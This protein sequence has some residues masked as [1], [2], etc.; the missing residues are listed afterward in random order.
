MSN[1]SDKYKKAHDEL[2]ISGS[3]ISRT[4]QMMRAIRDGEYFET[5]AEKREREARKRRAVAFKAVSAAAAAAACI[6]A[7]VFIDQ[8]SDRGITARSDMG[9]PAEEVDTADIFTTSAVPE[10]AAA[11]KEPVF[12]ET[13]PSYPVETEITS[14]VTEAATEIFT[15]T[16]IAET[17]VQ[18]YAEEFGQ[19]E[20]KTSYFAET[21]VSYSDSGAVNVG[22]VGSSNNS[23]I[24][25][26]ELG[27][28]DMAD[29][30]VIGGDKSE[31]VTDEEDD[32]EGSEPEAKE[33]ENDE[34]VVASAL[35]ADGAVKS[36]DCFLSGE[37]TA[38]IIQEYT[39]DKAGVTVEPDAEYTYML[40]DFALLIDNIVEEN[41][42]N[43]TSSEG[44]EHVP[45][46]E[47]IVDMSD[48]NGDAVRICIASGR[49]YIVSFSGENVM[50][51]VF[52][53]SEEELDLIAEYSD[54]LINTQK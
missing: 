9:Y 10:T 39:S 54:R 53:L 33:S 34:I 25:E 4:E 43:M 29:A 27:Y 48:D 52:E 17:S 31:P 40:S 14:V 11:A 38:V 8:Y 23:I 18:V 13:D 22:I 37:Y 41:K 2:K 24:G 51:Y 20:E 3:F 32:Q 16:E 6:G 46:S 7:V 45:V 30:P 50:T 49:M 47:Y 15:E 28:V 26:D 21:H 1:F 12:A 36:M 42:E 44:E 35:D 19:R 5:E